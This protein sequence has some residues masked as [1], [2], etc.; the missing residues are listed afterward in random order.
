MAE[1]V[2]MCYRRKD[3][4]KKMQRLTTKR[5]DTLQTRR[6]GH[7]MILGAQNKCVTRLKGRPEC[8]AVLSLKRADISS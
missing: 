2:I 7:N 8:E 5:H 4:D 6:M 3:V 1:N